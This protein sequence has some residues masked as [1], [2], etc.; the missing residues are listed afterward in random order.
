MVGTRGSGLFAAAAFPPLRGQVTRHLGLCAERGRVFAN[1]RASLE[2]CL[3]AWELGFV[4]EAGQGSLSEA[5]QRAALLPK[6]CFGSKLPCPAHAS[7][8]IL[9]PLEVFLSG[10]N[11]PILILPLLWVAEGMGAFQR[12]PGA[13]KP[14]QYLPSGGCLRG[15]EV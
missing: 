5:G 4:R 13:E 10:A 6:H 12:A 15:F 1:T 14:F 2:S 7:F 3:P 8:A 11:S 9:P